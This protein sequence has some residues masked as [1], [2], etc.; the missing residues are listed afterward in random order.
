MTNEHVLSALADPTRRKLIARL[1]RRPHSV[2][3][4][5]GYLR[6]SQPAVSQHLAVLKRVK[7]VCSRADGQRRIYGLDPA[8]IAAARAYVDRIWAASLDSYA[9]TFED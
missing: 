2:G 1:E 4:L 5:A 7:L 9:K 3:E 6:V 8:G